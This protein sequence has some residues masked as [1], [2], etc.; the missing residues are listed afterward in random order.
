MSAVDGI[1]I[2]EAVAYGCTG[3][4]TALFSNDLAVS[5]CAPAFHSILSTVVADRR[6][7]CCLGETMNKRRNILGE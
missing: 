5:Q 2:S 4:M 3:I 7:L 6:V 1:L